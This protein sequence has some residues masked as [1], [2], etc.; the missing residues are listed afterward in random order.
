[1]G[2]IWALGSTDE[3]LYHTSNPTRRGQ[4]SYNLIAGQGP[5]LTP[6]PTTL[7]TTGDPGTTQAPTPGEIPMGTNLIRVTFSLVESTITFTAVARTTGYVAF[8]FSNANGM[9]DA[10]IFIAGVGPN[11]AYYLVLKNWVKSHPKIYIKTRFNSRIASR[12]DMPY[13]NWTLNKTGI[14]FPLR[15]PEVKQPSCFHAY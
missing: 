9:A 14:S 11:N 5:P 2:I 3:L 15:N 8:G 13:Q 10:D 4:A 6:P 12:A 1:M 7:L